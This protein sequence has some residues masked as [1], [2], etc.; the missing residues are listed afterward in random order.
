MSKEII[1]ERELEI[2]RDWEGSVSCSICGMSAMEKGMW[3]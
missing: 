1:P 3:E 2:R